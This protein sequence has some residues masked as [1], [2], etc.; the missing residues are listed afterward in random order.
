MEEMKMEGTIKWVLDY[1]TGVGAS[2]GKSWSKQS[3]VMAKASTS[4]TYI[5]YVTFDVWGD[6][7]IKEFD[8]KVGDRV[9]VSLD[10]NAREYNGRW[11]NDIRVYRVTHLPKVE[12]PAQEQPK[13]QPRPQQVSAVPNGVPYQAPAE[14]QQAKEDDLPF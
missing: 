11:Y 9:E 3:Y 2:S 5:D 6:D 14:Q 12:E 4:G 13:A 10:I 8:L 1:K 7:R